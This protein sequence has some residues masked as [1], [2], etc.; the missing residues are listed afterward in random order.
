MLNKTAT[1]ERFSAP[2]GASAFEVRNLFRGPQKITCSEQG[3]RK[4]RA[5]HG[6]K[7]N[8]NEQSELLPVLLPNHRFWSEKIPQSLP[9]KVKK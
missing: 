3:F 9:Y 8:R 5:V 6:L 7:S 1:L 2:A 4:I